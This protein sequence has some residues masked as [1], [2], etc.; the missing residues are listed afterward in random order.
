MRNHRRSGRQWPTSVRRLVLALLVLALLAAACSSASTPA[1]SPESQASPTQS[2]T[3]TA[4][5]SPDTPTPETPA[6]EPDTS[7]DNA[8]P[9]YASGDSSYLFDQDKLHTFELTLSNDAL[10]TL[11]ADPT[12]EEYVEGSLTFE[13][14]TIETV[15]IRYKGSVGAFVGCL[16]GPDPLNPSGSKTCT[17]LSMKVK[18]NWE[19]EDTFYGVKKLQLHSMNLD[20]SQMRERLGYHLFREMGIPG[21]RAVHAMVTLNGVNVGLFTLVEQIDGRFAR[22]NFEDGTG[23]VYKEVWP[24][25]AAGQP[26]PEGQI[27][28]GLK[29]NE[30]EDPTVARMQAFGQALADATPEAAG[31]VI[32]EFMDVDQTMAYAAVDRTIRHDDG[33]FHWYCFGAGSCSNHN[34][35]W[36]E[37]PITQQ[38]HL[39]PWD[40]GNA[41]ENLRRN[42][43]PVTPV[44]DAWGEIT[45]DCD[46]YTMPGTFAPQR[47]AACDP[48][49]GGWV[50]FDA[51]YNAAVDRFLAGPFSAPEV[52]AVLDAWAEQ[53]REATAAAAE[54]HSDAPTVA[55]WE[56]SL[57]ILRSDIEF[58]QQPA[59]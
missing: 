18:V 25:D 21:P 50:T 6:S 7:D 24:V 27:L 51:Q 4:A 31:D 58:A 13:G 36:Y 22:E 39:I 52:D 35:Y 33:P 15:G 54:A 55:Q 2:P 32:T 12:A 26:T 30:N 10:L 57:Q 40:L 20:Q 43:N 23:N 28:E 42:A 29:T 14:E 46:A 16:S 38:L 47:S 3:P 44:G 56:A 37:D 9:R 17:K 11:D 5:T 49:M 48:L 1:A 19:G 8:E 59:N 41:F 53:I 34:Y 45:N